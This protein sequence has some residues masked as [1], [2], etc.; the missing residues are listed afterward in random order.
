MT[1]KK[2]KTKD[3][4]RARKLGEEAWE[5]VN[6]E[7]LDLALKL[8]RRAV[9]TQADN[10]VLWNDLGAIHLLANDLDEAERAFRAAQSLAI[11]YAE[12]YA[13]LATLRLRQGRL[14][15]AVAYQQKALERAPDSAAFAEHLAE[16][17]AMLDE[18]P[19][20]P[21]N[22]T[23]RPV[24]TPVPP[25]IDWADC[26]AA[27]DWHALGKRLSRE[28]CVLLADLVESDLCAQARSWFADDALFAKTVVMNRP[29]YG[30]GTYR[31]FRPPIPPLVDALRRAFYPHAARIA[32][33]WQ[34]LL[35]ESAIFPEEWDDFRDT[36]HDSGQT[37]STPILLRYEAGGFNALHRDLRGEAYFPLQL[38]IVLSPLLEEG[39][40][41]EGFTGGEFLLCDVPGSSRSQRRELR[42]GL[43][44]AILFCTRDRLVNTGGTHALQP[45]MHG[46]ATITTGT[47]YV[48]GVPFH[49]YR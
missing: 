16:Y 3:R 36:C 12:P 45:V 26:L 29:E 43:G 25:E 22:D 32:N 18:S 5:A 47:R 4:R 24:V 15:A 42:A 48:L 35:G 17:R 8:A 37:V 30:F 20:A 2:Q 28:G 46:V 27:L 7:N 40:T 10:P 41:G 33:E 6:G 11:G 9:D 38:A 1:A 23:T 19:K 44:D 13:N 14:E 31:Y 34:S 39:E 49:E 21:A